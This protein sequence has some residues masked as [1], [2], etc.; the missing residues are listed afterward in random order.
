[1]LSTVKKDDLDRIEVSES[2]SGMSEVYSFL[3]PYFRLLLKPVRRAQMQR[4]LARGTALRCQD[5][6]GSGPSQRARLLETWVLLIVS[7]YRYYAGLLTFCPIVM[8]INKGRI[9]KMV[10]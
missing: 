3:K 4:I 9:A 10:A 6:W 5:S 8:V 1:M 7:S 2:Q